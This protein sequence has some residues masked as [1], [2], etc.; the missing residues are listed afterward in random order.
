M[1]VLNY[2]QH[3]TTVSNLFGLLFWNVLHFHVIYLSL[4][5]WASNRTYSSQAGLK[6]FQPNLVLLKP[7]AWKIDHAIQLKWPCFD[8]R[9]LGVIKLHSYWAWI[10]P[11]ESVKGTSY[12]SGEHWWFW[13]Y[14][15][16]VL[17][18]LTK[19]PQFCY[20]WRSKSMCL[21]YIQLLSRL[22]W[23][24]SGNMPSRFQ[25]AI[26]W[27]SNS[28]ASFKIFIFNTLVLNF[29]TTEKL[30]KSEFRLT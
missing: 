25:W 14:S 30:H 18:N 9:L 8:H 12:I 6:N 15:Y 1:A 24:V 21:F 23:C 28:S 4:F 3:I 10:Q 11:S 17:H 16:N 22:N 13:C 7:S 29:L 27:I 26:S 19:M 2:C 20:L 5:F